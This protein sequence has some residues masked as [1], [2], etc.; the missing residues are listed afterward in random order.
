MCYRQFCLTRLALA[1]EEQ[2]EHG[3]THLGCY[4]HVCVTRLALSN[5]SCQR[6]IKRIWRD[7]RLRIILFYVGLHCIKLFSEVEIIYIYILKQTNIMVCGFAD[8]KK[9]NK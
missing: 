5:M 9:V 3:E 1:R 8:R 2:N 4:R 7:S 6:R